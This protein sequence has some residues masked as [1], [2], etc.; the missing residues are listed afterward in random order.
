MRTIVIEL[1]G[2]KLF[3]LNGLV[4]DQGDPRSEELAELML[5]ARKDPDAVAFGRMAGKWIAAA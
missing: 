1:E 5:A 3:V 4:T 2:K